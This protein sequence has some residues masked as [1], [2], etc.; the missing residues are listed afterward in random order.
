MAVGTRHTDHVAPSN[1]KKLAL[2]SLPSGGRSV[3]IV[4]LPT[5]AME[6]FSLDTSGIVGE[7]QFTYFGY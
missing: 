1:R 5:E 3:G 6:F 2:I 4:R 7:I